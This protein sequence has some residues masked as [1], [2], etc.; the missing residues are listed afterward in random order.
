VRHWRE[1]L[2]ARA[3]GGWHEHAL[4]QQQ[5]RIVA[6]LVANRRVSRLLAVAW[7]AWRVRLAWCLKLALL[8]SKADW[9]GA[10]AH[11]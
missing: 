6:R 11:H 5:H 9:W 1:R 8:V 3:L 2:L 4:V 10:C 7:T